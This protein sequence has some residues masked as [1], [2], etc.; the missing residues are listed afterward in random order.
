MPLL[1][2]LLALAA[3]APLAPPPAPPP[4]VVQIDWQAHPAMHIPWKMFGRG[5]TERPLARRTWK[6]QFRQTMSAPAVRDSGVRL[7]LAAAMAAERAR[8]PR[9]AR[10]LVLR[11]LAFVE[12]FVAEHPADFALAASPAEARVLLQTTD[13]IVVVHSIEGMHELLWEDGDAAFWAGRG[14]ALA[15]LIH[16]RDEELGGADLLD[17]AL[18]RMVNPTGARRIRRQE[19]R[20]LTP[21]GR[22]RM[23]D[24]HAAG[25]L[26]DLSHMSPASVDDALEVA[27]QHGIAPVVT[28]GRLERLRAGEFGFTDDQV[29][30]IYRLGGA[31]HVGLTG[32]E[33]QADHAPAGAPDL[34][35]GSLEAWSWHQRS[36]Q[37]LL[38]DRSTE[39][40]GHPAASDDDAVRLAT[41]WSSDWNGWLSHSRPTHGPQGCHPAD[42]ATLPIDTRGLAH[43]GL[44]PQHWQRVAEQGVDLQPMQRSAEQFLRLWARAR[45]EAPATPPAPAAATPRHDPWS[46]PG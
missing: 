14:V 35:W 31:F 19:R 17:G 28:H 40:L 43:P 36:L 38:I 46:G 2:L 25:I 12:R 37:Q 15:T 3:A 26:V 41:G 42:D 18:G 7:I 1:V 11:Q 4:V 27:R 13:Q 9:Q 32:L 44:L 10:R 23:V 30:E 45:G 21:L 6:H 20:G 39:I 5:L 8:N 16:L 34:C 24:L 29:V 22:Q 33:L